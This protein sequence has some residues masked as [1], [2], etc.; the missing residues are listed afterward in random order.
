MPATK[1]Q[2]IGGVFQDSEGNVLDS[3]YLH[4][5]LNQDENIAGVGQIAAG[6][7]I[8][9]NLNS[10]G[11]VD[12]STPQYVWGNDQMTPANSFY[13][14]TGFKSNGQL[15]WGPNNQQVNGSGGTFDV[16]TWIP[17]VV[18]SWTY[19]AVYGP[20]GPTGAGG[21]GP[22]GPTG[23]GVT[24]PTGATGATG[25]FNGLAVAQSARL[26]KALQNNS[27]LPTPAAFGCIPAGVP[28]G[29][30][31]GGLVLYHATD[32][33]DTNYTGFTTNA[34]NPSQAVWGLTDSCNFGINPNRGQVYL[35]PNLKLV[36]WHVCPIDT[37]A[38]RLWFVM[39]TFYTGNIANLRSDAPS[40]VSYF[41]F[42]YSTAA[43]DTNWQCVSAKSGVGQTVVDS[44][45]A[46]T[47]DQTGDT[48]SVLVSSTALQFYINGNF[49]TTITT[50]L[51][52]TTT[53]LGD[54]LSI[55]NAGNSVAKGVGLNAVRL[56]D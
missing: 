20:T 11:S 46:V 6:I 9:I 15:A 8:T 54:I 5:R 36:E 27:G 18:V 30:S 37:A 44:G 55:D 33:Y 38:V 7:V 19:P 12:T 53:H 41:G 50:N 3:G 40:S 21:A 49:I 42:R 43:P 13:V 31:P 23:A 2:L 52:A 28:T 17:N 39:G 14:V 32:G 26:W 29:T 56:I 24:G 22:T 48:L 45:V 35:M 51:P 1:V 47:A 16:G 4:M 10:S 34:A 25:A